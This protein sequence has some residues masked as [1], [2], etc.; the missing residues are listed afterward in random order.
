MLI[1]PTMGVLPPIGTFR[2]GARAGI[3]LNILSKEYPDEVASLPREHVGRRSHLSPIYHKSGK[4]SGSSSY[5][6][7][8]NKGINTRTTLLGEIGLKRPIAHKQVL[9]KP[10]VT[11][12]GQGNLRNIELSTLGFMRAR[13]AQMLA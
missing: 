12:P 7:P 10:N 2:E 9:T 4:R 8:L 6:V 1:I 13:K 11:S 5:K 3:W